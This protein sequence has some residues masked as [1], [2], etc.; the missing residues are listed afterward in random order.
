MEPPQT[1]VHLEGNR[2]VLTC[3]AEGSWPLEFKWI[4]N[5]SELTRFSL[6]YR[7]GTAAAASAATALISILFIMVIIVVAIMRLPHGDAL[8][9]RLVEANSSI[10]FASSSSAMDLFRPAPLGCTNLAV[11]RQIFFSSFPDLYLA[12]CSTN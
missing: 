8:P 7:W 12:S 4:Y 10:V 3:M 11:A 1:Q 2:L 9:V 5:G 6:E